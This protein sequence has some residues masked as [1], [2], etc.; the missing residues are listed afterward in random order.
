MRPWLLMLGGLIAWAVHFFTLYI[1]ASIFLTTPLARVLTL[2]VTVLL[3]AADGAL[4]WW[5]LRDISS[6]AHDDIVRWRRMLA[7]LAA[8]IAFV[9]IVWQAF[10]A[11]LA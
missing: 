7:V 11:V 5:L 3:L 9:A 2:I 1:I 4:L 8:A 6:D 10:P